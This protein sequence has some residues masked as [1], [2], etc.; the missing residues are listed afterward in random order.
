MT[1]VL[2]GVEVAVFLVGLALG[3][4]LLVVLFKDL[5]R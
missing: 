3:L 1:V 5:L 4:G 2:E